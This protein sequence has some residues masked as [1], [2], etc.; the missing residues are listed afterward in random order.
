MYAIL[1]AMGVVSFAVAVILGLRATSA[2]VAQAN[3]MASMLGSSAIFGSI[4]VVAF[5]TYFINW[6]L[7]ALEENLQFVTWLGIIYNTYWTRV[8]YI[9]KLEIVQDELEVATNDTIAKINE[10]MNKHTERSGKRP[11]ITLP[12]G[13]SVQNVPPPQGS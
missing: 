1:F 13:A 11:T 3:A 2:E 12:G 9:H 7:Q 8:A 10:L 6:H 4:S 5:L